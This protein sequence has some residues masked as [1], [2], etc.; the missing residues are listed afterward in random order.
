MA[1]LSDFRLF[2]ASMVLAY[3][4]ALIGLNI[5][6][7]F[8]GQVSLG[9]GAFFALGAYTTAIL[10]EHFG[11]PYWIAIPVG[12]VTGFAAGYA[13]GRPALRL[14]GIYLGLATF[15]L[16]VATPQILKYH[17]IEEWTGGVQGIFLTKP[18]A[19][20]GLPLSDDQWFYLYTLFVAGIVYWVARWLLESGTGRAFRAIRDNPLAA[21]AIG[22][23]TRHHKFMAFGISAAFTAIGGGLAA[24]AVQFVAP[25]AY[26][27]FLSVSLLVG[28]VVGGVGT[29][30]GA[31]LGALFIVY[32]PTLADSISKSAP[33]AVYGVA[34]I[35]LVYLMPDGIAGSMTKA[36]RMRIK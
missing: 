5:L 7:G 32:V 31:A 10:M 2:Q 21:E 13:F 24:V 35:V 16:A 18:S 25:D 23:D 30:S 27:L 17:A 15:A 20:F 8:S 3:A 28:A 36:I 22:I 9:H 14:T 6:T 11:V 33:W 12:G 26:D 29:L 19:P 34:L 1:V 4:T